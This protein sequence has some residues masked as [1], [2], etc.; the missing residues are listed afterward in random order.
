[1]TRPAPTGEKRWDVIHRPGHAPSG[2]GALDGAAGPSAPPGRTAGRSPPV[3]PPLPPAYW[4]SCPGSPPP[5]RLSK[6][7]AGKGLPIPSLSCIMFVSQFAGMMELVDVTD[8]KSVGGNIVSVRVRLPAPARRKR[9][10]AC[11]EFFISLQNSSR[12]YSAA[13]HFQTGPAV[14]GLRFGGGGGGG[15]GGSFGAKSALLWHLFMPR[16]KKTSSARSLTSPSQLRPAVLGPQ[17]A[18]SPPG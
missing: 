11:D 9:H 7:S 14:A 18:D 5:T 12:A 3:M 10:I 1:M 4:M 2:S 15:G 17:L 6:I 16:A 8:S 13:P